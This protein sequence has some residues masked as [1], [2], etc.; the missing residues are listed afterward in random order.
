MI[1]EFFFDL[2]DV[3]FTLIGVR[4][5]RAKGL[6]ERKQFQ[7]NLPSGRIF[8]GPK[9]RTLEIGNFAIETFSDEMHRCGLGDLLAHIDI[10]VSRWGITHLADPI[11]TVIDI[12][13]ALTPHTGMLLSSTFYGIYGTKPTLDQMTENDTWQS[14]YYSGEASHKIFSSCGNAGALVAGLSAG[15]QTT[16]ILLLKP[17]AEPAKIPLQYYDTHRT[18]HQQQN[19]SGVVQR[20]VIADS[21][22]AKVVDHVPAP[23]PGREIDDSNSQ[24]ERRGYY[25]NMPK[26]AM[27]WFNQF[28]TIN[29]WEGLRK[30]KAWKIAKQSHDFL[31]PM[32]RKMWVET[33]ANLARGDGLAPRRCAEYQPYTG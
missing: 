22:D 16:D 28:S 19:A 10:A 26:R 5:E 1:H 4:G 21:S 24:C 23:F 11:G 31:R 6:D 27:R 3:Q 9:I 25:A 14:L 13:N 33:Q 12:Y 32:F 2:A 17:D 15:L 7:E 20:F 30:K 8:H 18:A 29:F